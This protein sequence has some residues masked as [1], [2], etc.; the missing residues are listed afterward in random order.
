MT[1]AKGWIYA[2]VLLVLLVLG[3][4]VY[5]LVREHDA[6]VKAEAA[7]A[8][9]QKNFD[10][11]QQ[12]AKTVQSNLSARLASLEQQKQVPATAPQIV[13]DAQK[14]FPNL[15]AQLQVVQP[16]PTQQTVNGKT[17]DVPSAPV[18]QVPAADFQALQD[19][20]IACQEDQAKLA[21]CGLTAAD[22]QKELADTQTERDAY[23][24]ALKGGTFWTRFKH[25]AKSIG[26]T[27]L[28]AGGAAYAAGH[29][30]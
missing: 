14:L 20:A 7:V 24:T 9:T 8:A 3:L 30:K 21:A 10:E 25:D 23:K 28:I 26:I 13:I 17:V 4:G 6:R 22:T 27:A 16:P 5:E 29:A 1:I 19:G 11:A 15:P 2:G 18:V 12:D